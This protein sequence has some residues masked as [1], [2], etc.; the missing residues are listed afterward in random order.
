MKIGMWVHSYDVFLSS[1]YYQN[2]VLSLFSLH[3]S[4]FPP[5][6]HIAIHPPMPSFSS[7]RSPHIL[8][9]NDDNEKMRIKKSN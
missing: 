2:G 8:Q 7:F 3:S 4:F 9:D 1:S 5:S 6:I